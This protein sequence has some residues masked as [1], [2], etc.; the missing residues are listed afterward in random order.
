LVFKS[1]KNSE[2]SASRTKVVKESWEE[3][4]VED[5]KDAWDVEEEEEKKGLPPVQHF[6]VSI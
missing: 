1:K 2:D 3:E 6:H 5:V 4:E